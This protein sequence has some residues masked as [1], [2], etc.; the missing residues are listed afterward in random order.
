MEY[1]DKVKN[2]I[3]NLAP[4]DKFFN[5]IWSFGKQSLVTNAGYLFGISLFNSIVGLFFWGL[6]TRLYRPEEVGFTSAFISAAFLVCGITDFGM[7]VGLV[8]CLPESQK[9]INFL[10]TIFTLEALTTIL[11]GVVYL[12]GISIWTP[13]LSILQSYWIYLVAFLIY[14]TFYTLGYFVRFSFIARRKSQYALFY[15]CISNVS[16]L[17]F[18]ILFA[19]L[20]SLGLSVTFTFSFFLATSISFIFFMPKVEPD[21][22]LYPILDWSVISTIFPYS[23]GNFLVGLLSMAS[24]RLLPLLI[25][26]RLGPLSS[27]YF[28]IAWMIGDFLASPGSAISDSL[29]AEGSNS[30]ESLMT[31][32]IKSAIIGLVITIPAAILIGLGSPYILSI[33]GPNYAREASSLLR[34]LAMASIL[35]VINGLYFTKL[36]VQ[37]QIKQLI[38]VNAIL[39]FVTLGITY[40]LIP[41]V[42]IT[43]VGIGWL[44][45]N[46]LTSLGTFYYFEWHK[47]VISHFSKIVCRNNRNPL[48]KSSEI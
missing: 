40:Y 3:V 1:G 37:K 45:G 42:G 48:E 46:S 36:K 9:P 11:A 12:G 19:G 6:A 23:L 21:Y 13:S 20:G 43:A 44:I 8:R 2:K 38:L 29:F 22:R 34:W 7:S 10:N 25:I 14:I 16:R 47:E 17:I 35:T 31:H 30:P 39:T 24:Q 28:Y 27:A 41:R 32:L 26:E 18:V 33:F 15:T 4:T 5:R